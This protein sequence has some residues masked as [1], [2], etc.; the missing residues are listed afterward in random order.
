[1]VVSK[2]KARHMQQS[3]VTSINIPDNDATTEDKTTLSADATIALSPRSHNLPSVFTSNK[4]G[5][6]SE[7]IQRL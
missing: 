1:M 5:E 3:F 4:I 7:I 6:S 2:I